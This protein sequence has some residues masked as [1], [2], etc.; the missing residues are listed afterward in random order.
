[1]GSLWGHR[2]FG[3]IDGISFG[4]SMGPHWGHRWDLIG[5]IGGI[6]FGTSM[7]SL[8]GARDLGHGARDLGLGISESWQR[9]SGIGPSVS[10]LGIWES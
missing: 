2:Y 9:I 10:V 4:T 5:D 3:D 1:M 8:W 6:S 7:G